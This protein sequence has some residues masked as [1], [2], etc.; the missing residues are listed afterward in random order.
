MVVKFL[1]PETAPAA[2]FV[3]ATSIATPTS[4]DTAPYMMRSLSL[5]VV[6]ATSAA[7]VDLASLARVDVASLVGRAQA[8]DDPVPFVDMPAQF[9]SDFLLV[10]AA[11]NVNQTFSGKIWG[12]TPTKQQRLSGT[13][14]SMLSLVFFT[15][16]GFLTHRTELHP[17]RAG[18]SSPSTRSSPQSP[19]RSRTSRTALGVSSI[20][21]YPTPSRRTTAC[22]P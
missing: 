7:A 14:V 20:P 17:P 8:S 4:A 21:T 16:G 3:F 2:V 19:S 18:K 9:S 10:Q 11:G 13:C 5:V 12:S 22:R 15:A 6:A 1:T